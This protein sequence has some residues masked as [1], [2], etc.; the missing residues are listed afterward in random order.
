MGQHQCFTEPHA[1]VHSRNH[2]RH[3]HKLKHGRQPVF[4]NDQTLSKRTIRAWEPR[5]GKWFGT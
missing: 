2:G 3:W 4:P 1:R 5:Y